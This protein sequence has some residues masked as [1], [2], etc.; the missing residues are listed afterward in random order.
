MEVVIMLCS[1]GV[2]IY[3][4]MIMGRIKIQIAWM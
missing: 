2:F 3:V 4:R 1:V